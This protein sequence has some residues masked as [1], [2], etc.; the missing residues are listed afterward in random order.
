M[1][2]R[3]EGFTI[4]ELVIVIAVIAILAAV[5][6][7]TFSSLIRK[8]NLSN[9]QSTIRNMNTTLA[10]ESASQAEIQYAGDAVT[11]LNANG[12]AGKYSPYSSGYHYGFHLESKKMYLIDSENQ[13]VFPD[14]SVNI[15]DLWILWSNNAIDKVDGA[16]K[17][18]SLVNV[19]GK[20]GYFGTH[21]AGG[22]YT[23]DLA[24]HYIAY[25]GEEMSN[26]T[27]V[28]GIF[29]SGATTGE[30]IETMNKGNIANVTGGT[31]DAAMVYE[32]LVFDCD[33]V[34]IPSIEN[35][36]YRNCFFY[37]VASLSS[38]FK[39]TTYENCNFVESRGY[40]FNMASTAPFYTGT[41][42]VT[43][44]TFVNCARIFNIPLGVYGQTEEGAVIITGNTF[45]GV[46]D[47]DRVAIQLN[48]QLANGKASRGSLDNFQ[49]IDITVSDNHFVEISTSQAGL[50]SLHETTIITLVEAVDFDA[51][52]ITIENNAID[53]SIPVSKY[54]VNYDGKADGAFS[55]YN[56]SKLKKE[57]TDKMTAGRK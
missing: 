43:G 36:T 40:I 38:R 27:A 48:T 6:I 31:S 10:I 4:V 26:V 54:V 1:K 13:A 17:Y 56:A 14:N 3:K 51:D 25:S 35:V 28:N 9:D 44:C 57:L 7:P 53:S 23:L 5:L 8:A 39:N 24:G 16:T 29:V 42:T 45:Y 50:I 37:N 52:H 33:G 30:G 41:L 15:A 55:P 34:S 22:E 19:N 11:I 21:F 47:N 46:T 20:G 49:Y 12:F 32:N 18:V 2:K